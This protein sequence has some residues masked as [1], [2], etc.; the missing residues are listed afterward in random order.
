MGTAAN[1]L[2]PTLTILVMIKIASALSEFKVAESDE[3]DVERRSMS[4]VRVAARTDP[5]KKS[6]PRMRARRGGFE[7]DRTA[8]NRAA[9]ALEV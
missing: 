7:A 1:L 6:P 5:V 8:S 9:S 4:L 2:C 3:L